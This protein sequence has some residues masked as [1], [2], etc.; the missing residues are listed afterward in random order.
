MTSTHSPTHHDAELVLRLFEL[1]REE[2]LR[3]A[4]EWI[5]A[6]YP[7]SGE[8]LY[9]AYMS[10]DSAFL[11]MVAGYWDMA[12]ALVN[13]GTLN[14]ELFLETGGEALF[15]WAKI[16]D[17]VPRFRELAGSTVFLANV[18]RFVHETPG[19]HERVTAMK[20]TQK[21][22][23]ALREAQKAAAPA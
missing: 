22:I 16:G 2:K 3:K 1:R 18:E 11:R 9:A 10:G 8:D 4:R 7:S 17:H 5:A 20:E 6:F 14:R 23:R 12:T 13:L 15:L 19:A 21:R